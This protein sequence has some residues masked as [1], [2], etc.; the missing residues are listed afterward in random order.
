MALA[1]LWFQLHC[2]FGLL[3]T[4]LWVWD[5]ANFMF[6]LWLWLGLGSGRGLASALVMD[7]LRRQLWTGYGFG[8]G[9]VVVRVSVSNIVGPLGRDHTPAFV[10]TLVL[11]ATWSRLR[12]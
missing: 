2:D 1:A 8:C 5:A 10:L 3:Q 11:I 9:L 7:R 6:R 12:W 4:L